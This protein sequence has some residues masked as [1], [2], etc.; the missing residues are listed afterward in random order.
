MNIDG[1]GAKSIGM[2]P[3]PFQGAFEKSFFWLIDWVEPRNGL[4]AQ[5]RAGP[6]ARLWLCDLASRKAKIL[7]EAP[8]AGLPILSPDRSTVAI[9]LK[10][11]DDHKPCVALV[12][13]P[14][15]DMTIADEDEGRQVVG[16]TWNKAGDKLA[17]LVRKADADRPGEK[18]VLKVY[19]L[20]EKRVIAERT[21]SGKSHAPY[22]GRAIWLDDDRLAES[23]LAA[24][25]GLNVYSADLTQKTTYDFPPAAGFL[26]PVASVGNKIL[27]LNSD[28]YN[29]WRLDLKKGTWKRLY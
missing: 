21:L 29:L 18:P 17:Y 20:S 9:Y 2:N 27:A 10:N 4:L 26:A 7:F 1:T 15:G 5:Q 28:L 13:L 8:L 6:S 23:S 24:V 12:S 3:A 22:Y 11:P 25:G 16:L 19:S 14:D